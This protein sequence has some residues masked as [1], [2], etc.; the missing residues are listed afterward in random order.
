MKKNN[1]LAGLAETSKIG[2]IGLFAG[3]FCIIFSLGYTL[4]CYVNERYE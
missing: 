1:I 4:V 2:L 3:V